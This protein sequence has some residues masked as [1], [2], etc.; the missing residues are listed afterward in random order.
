MR[1]TEHNKI[2]PHSVLNGR[3][4]DEAYF[5]RAENIPEE[6]AAARRVSQRYDVKEVRRCAALTQRG[7][8]LAQCVPAPLE[9]DCVT[10]PCRESGPHCLEGM[11]IVVGVLREVDRAG[12][13]RRCTPGTQRACSVPRCVPSK[14]RHGRRWR[15]R[16]ENGHDGSAIRS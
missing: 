8:R 1:L 15:C 2:L 11:A 13:P 5:G 9:P 3:T 16:W 14:T 12:L 10:R 6:L 4:P 7:A